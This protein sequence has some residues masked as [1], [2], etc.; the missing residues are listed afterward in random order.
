MFSTANGRQIT[1][2]Y[3]FVLGFMLYV[4]L[5]IRGES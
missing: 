2:V 3:K 5:G 1:Q 4:D